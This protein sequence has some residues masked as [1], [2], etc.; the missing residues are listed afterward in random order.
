MSVPF[1][2]LIREAEQTNIRLEMMDGVPVWEASP[3]FY[4]QWELKRIEN[5]IRPL[6]GSVCACI[7]VADVLFEFAKTSFKRPDIAVLCQLPEPLET[8]EALRVVPGAVIEIISKNY[9][10][11]DLVLSPPFYLGHGV[12]DVV[13]FDPRSKVV[14]HHRH[15]W[16]EPRRLESPVRLELECGCEV[17]V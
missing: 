17:M 15:E 8:E 1:R 12:K 5:S 9:E 11:K 3:A 13:V 10:Y 16:T 4:H 7:S 2:D 6:A 14:L